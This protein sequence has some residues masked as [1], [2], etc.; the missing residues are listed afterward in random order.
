M[1][2]SEIVIKQ[3]PRLSAIYWGLLQSGYDYFS[4]ERNPELTALIESFINQ[5]FSSPFFAQA[6]QSSCEA[7]HFWPR[8]FILEA[9]ALCLDYDNRG[10]RNY[11]MLH[12]RIMTAPNILDGERD[13]SLW[14]WISDFPKELASILST[15]SFISYSKW[16]RGWISEQNELNREALSIVKHCLDI[17]VDRYK[18][19]VDEIQICI[20]PIKCVYASDYHLNG[21]C[22]IFTSGELRV[23]SV[24][25]EFLHHVVHPEVECK[26]QMILKHSHKDSRIDNSYYLSGDDAGILNGFEEVVVRALTSRI[27]QDD[28]PLNLAT[29]IDNQIIAIE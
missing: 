22:F 18:S 21:S 23:D 2:A 14:K 5:Q 25:H 10:F 8:A 13:A 11:E 20:N 9:A 4:I 26:K 12:N 29:F 17:C 24:I 15:D 6:R 19:S 27:M 28:Y 7:Y 1:Y 3:H 16:E